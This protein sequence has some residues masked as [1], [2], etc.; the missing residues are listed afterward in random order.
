M[1]QLPSK[2]TREQGIAAKALELAEKLHSADQERLDRFTLRNAVDIFRNAGA[3]EAEAK[4]LSAL[5]SFGI[6]VIS[7]AGLC[8]MSK[9]E[10]E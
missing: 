3:T 1:T 8:A 6:V 10:N 7:H 4:L 2:E 5:I 9:E